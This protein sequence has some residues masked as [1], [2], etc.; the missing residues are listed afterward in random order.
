MEYIQIPLSPKLVA[1]LENTK[2]DMIEACRYGIIL[3]QKKNE[4]IGVKYFNEEM[5]DINN[6][7]Y[8]DLHELFIDLHYRKINS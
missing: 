5:K 1:V 7:S 2:S 3:A 8:E 4:D 6:L